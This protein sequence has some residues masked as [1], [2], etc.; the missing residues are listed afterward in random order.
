M[1]TAKRKYLELCM[2]QSVNWLKAS[3]LSPSKGMS[4]MHV[5]LIHIAIRNKTGI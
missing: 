1:K 5:K 2:Q 3:A 4:K